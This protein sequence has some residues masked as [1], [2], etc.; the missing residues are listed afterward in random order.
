MPAPNDQP[1]RD[2]TTAPMPDRAGPGDDLGDYRLVSILG[3]GGFGTVYL[4]QRRT[5]YVQQVA[6][7]IV[8][9]GM[10]SAA[11]VERFTQE[12]Q[13]LASL[14]HPHV[15]RILDAGQTPQGRPYFVME[16]VPG[17]TITAFA[18]RHALTVEDRLRLFIPVC[19][20]VH[21]AHQR[22]LIHRDLKPSNI[23]V[24]QPEGH[25][26]GFPKVIDFGIARALSGV[27]AGATRPGAAVGTPEYMSPE[28]ARGEPVG[29]AS[30]VFTLGVVLFE[31]LTGRLPRE[32]P[33]GIDPLSPESHRVLEGV[34]PAR[35]SSIVPSLRGDLDVILARAMA[36]EPHRRY[37]SAEALADDL[38]RNLAR[39]PIAARRDS[40]LYVVGTRTRR[41]AH[42]QPLAVVLL[43]ATVG[44]LVA[45]YVVMPVLY[46]WTAWG[47]VFERVLAWIP[48]RDVGT[49]EHVVVITISE[50]PTQS[51]LGALAGVSGVSE[52]R[53]SLRLVHGELMRR[54]ANAGPAVAAFDIV[55][56]T[57]SAEATHDS[58]LAA[59][60]ASLHEAGV[61][62]VLATRVWP[63]DGG[64]V[65]VA[66]LLRESAGVRFGG[67]T[68]G[69]GD[70]FIYVH[71]FAQ[72]RPGLPEPSLALAAFAANH[73]PSA[74]PQIMVRE[75]D[76]AADVVYVTSTSAGAR[77]L[78]RADTLRAIAIQAC[79]IEVERNGLRPDDMLGLMQVRLPP[80][81]V[82]N[83]ATIP[84]DAVLAMSEADL[85][86]RVTGRI[87]VVGDARA[88]SNDFRTLPDGRTVAGC[89]I[90][91]TAI[92]QLLRG[93]AVTRPQEAV[94]YTMLA[95]LS[96]MG[97]LIGI[98]T[99][100]IGRL[101]TYVGVLVGLAGVCMAL[102]AL[103]AIYAGPL[104]GA[105]AF[106]IAGELAA[107][108][109]G[110][111]GLT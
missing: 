55:F 54:L 5:P 69:E 74:R 82:L 1:T 62:V 15:A 58:A 23:L 13:A 39:E 19:E 14:D 52:D 51:E 11:V 95:V 90:I 92:E 4:A 43:A 3:E 57:P 9:P 31:L 2:H 80:T 47:G 59:G 25:E 34:M 86:A 96:L 93:W 35:A 6:L 44:F 10:D 17:P 48:P 28:Q 33:S 81:P 60:L 38:R 53:A 77:R 7:K 97:A 103:A 71:L 64:L 50:G 108:A 49:F 29:P 110:R 40:V 24:A 109:R 89:H 37:A 20:A 73:E 68:L 32:L 105:G 72:R 42:R 70:Q 104:V 56:S 75:H 87:V 61:P 107:H 84:L 111:R 46:R 12:R 85:R 79:G 91:A 101:V 66:P 21:H 106:I 102:Y 41:L 99:R 65:R 45:T 67:V 22:G 36:H 8:K 76:D 94:H 18:Q 16:Y 63:I 78:P 27:S 26:G 100:P 83:A 30:D 88:V 98:R